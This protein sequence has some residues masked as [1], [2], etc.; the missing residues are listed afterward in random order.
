MF[1]AKKFEQGLRQYRRKRLAPLLKPE[2]QEQ[3]VWTFHSVE[4]ALRC[5]ADP[6]SGARKHM[7][8]GER[9]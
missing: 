8:G 7:A 5:L 2:E 6:N 9:K 1:D 3:R 4:E